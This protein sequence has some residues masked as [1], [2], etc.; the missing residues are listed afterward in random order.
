MISFL[1]WSTSLLN[2]L[3]GKSSTF[4]NLIFIF[5][6]FWSLIVF[7]FLSDKILFTV[8]SSNCF[9]SSLIVILR[10]SDFLIG[11]PPSLVISLDNDLIVSSFFWEDKLDILSFDLRYSSSCL[12]LNASTLLTPAAIDD[13][14]TT[15]NLPTSP[16]FFTCVPPQSSVEKYLLPSSPINTTLTSSPYFSPNKAIAPCSIPSSGVISRVT[17]SVFEFTNLLT[18]SSIFFISSSVIGFIW[19][20]SNLNLS[21]AT[22]DP[23]CITCVPKVLLRDSCNKCVAEWYALMFWRLSVFIFNSTLSLSL[24]VPFETLPKWTN[25]FPIFFWTS[26][27][28][29]SFSPEVIVPLSPTWPPDSP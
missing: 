2:S 23:F 6:I 27:T 14:L 25:K 13:W 21:G 8:I 7:F 20:K 16:V 17:T 29:N 4:W 9:V 12:S 24:I 1:P 19:L 28:S 3:K 22:N 26:V 10:S 5:L 18:F 11:F 15:L